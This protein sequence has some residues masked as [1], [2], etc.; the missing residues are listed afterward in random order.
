MPQTK[1]V[2]K[3]YMRRRREGSQTQ[4]SQEGFTPRYD[5]DLTAKEILKLHNERTQDQIDRFP[6]IPLP[7]GEAYYK[8][9]Q[10][11]T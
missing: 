5:H 6:M 10:E 9:L 7:F 2:H 8:A 4:G 1:E 11:R 3:E